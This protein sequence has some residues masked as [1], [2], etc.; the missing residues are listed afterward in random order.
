MYMSCI[1]T[2]Y[3]LWSR[4][5]TSLKSLKKERPR[6][7]QY[8][9]TVTDQPDP[10][11]FYDPGAMKRPTTGTRSFY[12]PE[13][14]CSHVNKL[15]AKKKTKMQALNNK[16]HLVFEINCCSMDLRPLSTALDS[17]AEET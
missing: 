7:Q 17:V 12:C 10:C 15:L 2:M 11:G 13:S 1:M 5:A 14:I 8:R 6:P 9:G 3:N 4:C 16:V